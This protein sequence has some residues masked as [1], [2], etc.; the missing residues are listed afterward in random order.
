MTEEFRKEGG[1]HKQ[2]VLLTMTHIAGCLPHTGQAL[3]THSTQSHSGSLHCWVPFAHRALSTHSTQ[4]H[5]GSMKSRLTAREAQRS[6]ATHLL[7]V[8][9]GESIADLEFKPDKLDLETTAWPS[10][11]KT[12][13]RGGET[14]L[15]HNSRGHRQEQ[16]QVHFPR[17]V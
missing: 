3:S 10:S 12:Y 8:I 14:W 17:L 15:K 1:H 11:L 16:T 2:R 7:Q 5:N 4:S 6:K 9:A 13:R